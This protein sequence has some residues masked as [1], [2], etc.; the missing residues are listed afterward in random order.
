MHKKGEGGKVMKR[1][2]VRKKVREE[3]KTG[4]LKGD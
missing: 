3:R 2:R 4:K 1:G